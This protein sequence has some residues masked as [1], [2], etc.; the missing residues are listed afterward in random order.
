MN[1]FFGAR[2]S[3]ST[4]LLTI[5]L[6][7]VV[8]ICLILITAF[9]ANVSLTGILKRTVDIQAERV[10]VQNMQKANLVLVLAAMDSI[11]D[12]GEGA[13]NPERLGIIAD[14]AATLRDNAQLAKALSERLGVAELTEDLENQINAVV[15]AI[16]VDLKAL[17]EAGAAE[18]EFARIDDAID[19]EGEKMSANLE[20]LHDL[21]VEESASALQNAKDASSQ[22]F[23]MQ[24]G[25]GVLVLT[26]CAILIYIHGQSIRKAVV[27]VRNAMEKIA[28]GNL[29]TAV[30]FVDRG[31]ELGE[32]ARTTEIFRDAA[33]EKGRLESEAEAARRRSE[34]EKAVLDQEK[35]AYQDQLAEAVRMLGDGLNKLANGDLAF[36]LDEPFHA[37]FET[38]RQDMNKSVKKLAETMSMIS[39]SMQTMTGSTEELTSGT[40]ELAKRTESQAASVEET[41]AA[42]DQIT[43]TVR[44]SQERTEEARRIAGEANKSTEHSS[45]I[46]SDAEH[47]M[48]RIES[49]SEKISSIIGVI[50]DIAFQTNLLALNAGVEAARA[51]EAG[52][53]FAVVAQEVRE[54]AQRSG[55]A[56]KEIKDLIENSSQEVNSGVQLVRQA[57]EAL[58]T[59]G[60]L[61]RDINAHMENIATAAK[62]Q[63]SGLAE[64]NSAVNSIDQKTQENAAMVEET[65]AATALMAEETEKLRQIVYAFNLP[66]ASAQA[67]MLRQASR[68]MAAPTSPKASSSAG[69]KPAPVKVASGGSSASDQWEEF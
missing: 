51:G 58:V 50:E 60:S 4:R 6:S 55:T 11:I 61:V 67:T 13:I 5:G 57:G 32:I 47:A 48:S 63:T 52:K 8:G 19:G 16:Q 38:L 36:S 30:P 39:T 3:I 23:L 45:A 17:I 14:S 31:D 44:T 29:Q 66:G 2:M 37:D 10:A 24:L 62:E 7:A 56:A 34:S 12:R 15:Q 46:V 65:S 35:A 18:E 26:V 53:G 25:L 41:A 40:S 64:I 69:M 9:L 43:A 54:L 28:S 1:G 42:L 22:S 59:I 20:K 68:V 21:A 49:S 27:G 33:E